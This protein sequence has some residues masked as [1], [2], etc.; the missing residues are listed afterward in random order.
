MST[1]TLKAVG[2]ILAGSFSIAG[3]IYNWDWFMEARKARSIVWLFG[4]NGARI[5]YGI[6]GLVIALI[7]LWALIGGI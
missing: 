3:G 2:L 5:F 4:R 7:G 6:L 1:N